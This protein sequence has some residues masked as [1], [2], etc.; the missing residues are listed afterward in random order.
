MRSILYLL[1]ALLTLS[2]PATAQPNV[3]VST[4]FEEPSGGFNKVLQLKNG[5]TFHFHITKGE[6][7]YTLYNNEHKQVMKR[8]IPGKSLSSERIGTATINGIFDI[9]GE[10]VIFF[11]Q[12]EG[13]APTLYRLR[14]NGSTGALV[15]DKAISSIEKYKSGSGFAIAYGAVQP[16]KFVVEHDPVSG[17]YAVL[18][19]HGLAGESGERLRLMHFSADHKELRNQF[20]GDPGKFKYIDFI[21]MIVDEKRVIMASYGYNTNASGGK[22]SRIIISRLR[23]GDNDFHHELLDY[24]DD[25]KATTGVMRYNPVTDKVHFLTCTFMQ[26][27][28][29]FMSSKINNYYLVLMSIFDPETLLP[30][31]IKPLEYR[32]MNYSYAENS[33]KTYQFFG[34]PQDM[35]INSDGSTTIVS[36]EIS[37]QIIRSSSGAESYRSQLGAIGVSTLD[38]RKGEEVGGTVFSKAQFVTAR[39]G[40]F[41]QAEARKGTW[42]FMPFGVIAQN[43][44]FFSFDYIGTAQGRYI[45]FND[46]PENQ[47]S[48]RKEAPKTVKDVSSTNT[49]G[50]TLGKDEKSYHVFGKPASDKESTFF[51]LQ[52]SDYQKSTGTYATIIVERTGRKKQSRI[53][54]LKFE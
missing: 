34:L 52:A 37:L 11:T 2:R 19:Y 1:I 48:Y 25:F 31:Q 30:V 17:A 10:A 32:D 3:S 47:E 51:Y 13:R 12:M 50:F 45:M 44:H 29:K 54:W 15:E 42:Q 6:I 46:Y 28:S 23:D 40:A 24:T 35:I 20:Y 14:F 16:S 33:K 8:E 26:T 27:K 49:Y 38:T 41:D 7:N 22:D 21:A 9:N 4:P 18:A 5:N 39:S 36:E 53:A 43:Q